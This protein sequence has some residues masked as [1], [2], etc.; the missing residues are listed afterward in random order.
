MMKNLLLALSI[1][2]ESQLMDYINQL[3]SAEKL[4]L[5][6]KLASLLGLNA[7]QVRAQVLRILI[8]RARPLVAAHKTWTQSISSSDSVRRGIVSHL[9]K[10]AQISEE[11]IEDEVLTAFE[12]LVSNFKE[13][14]QSVKVSKALLEKAK[15]RCGCCG[16]LFRDQDLEDLDL[17]L[18]DEQKKLVAVLGRIDRFHPV[19]RKENYAKP[20]SDHIWPISLYGSNNENNIRIL[21]DACNSGKANYM[22]ADHAAPNV[23]V[24]LPKFFTG[25]YVDPTVF[26]AVMAR[27]KKCVGCGCEPFQSPLTVRLR[28]GEGVLVPDNLLTV[29]YSCAD[30]YDQ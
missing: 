6:Q 26:Y 23:G 16:F 7:E 13:Q 27:D 4:D 12:T 19:A 15:Y 1:Y 8:E 28:F 25:S 17:E 20:R 11:D 22:S 3:P 29:C 5:E 9:E 21:C 24:Y 14:R 10:V 30:R 2:G 18:P